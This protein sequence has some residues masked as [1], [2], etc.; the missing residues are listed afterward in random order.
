MRQ[1]NDVGTQYRSAIYAQDAAQAE[2]AK[3]SRDAYQQRLDNEGFGRITTEIAT[4]GDFF[5]AEDYH[6]QY[7]AKNPQGYCGLAGT[8]VSCPTGLVDA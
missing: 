3:R 4:L 8:G 5:Y 1:G 6:Q 2:A 7:L